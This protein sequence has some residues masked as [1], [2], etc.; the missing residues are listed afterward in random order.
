M[1][2]IIEA[3]MKAI[4]NGAIYVLNLMIIKMD[5]TTPNKVST[6]LVI[7]E[8]LIAFNLELSLI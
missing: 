2:S 1:G 7:Y 5:T 6:I 4:I 3:I 8:F